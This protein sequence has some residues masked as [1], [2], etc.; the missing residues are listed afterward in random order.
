MEKYLKKNG[1]P[2]ITEFYWGNG[3]TSRRSS[4]IIEKAKAFPLIDHESEPP[5]KRGK[6]SVADLKASKQK[7]D[8][9]EL[10]GLKLSRLKMKKRLENQQRRWRKDGGIEIGRFVKTLNKE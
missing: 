3:E 2:N 9:K 10:E 6:K 1:G 7:I 5:K 8:D 4:R